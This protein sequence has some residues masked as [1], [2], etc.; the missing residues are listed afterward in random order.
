MYFWNSD[1]FFNGGSLKLTT[2][3]RKSESIDVIKFFGRHHSQL[4]SIMDH[5]NYCY[6]L[7]VKEMNKSINM[8]L[9]ENVMWLLSPLQSDYGQYGKHIPSYCADMLHLL[10]ICYP[11]EVIVPFVYSN[12]FPMANCVSYFDAAHFIHHTFSD[13]RGKTQLKASELFRFKPI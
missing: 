1:R 9:P 5:I 7:Q 3:I 11:P 8:F 2:D 12:P 10:S 4:V 6:S 13:E